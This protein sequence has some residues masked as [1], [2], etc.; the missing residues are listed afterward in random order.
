MSEIKDAV[1][2]FNLK[3]LENVTTGLPYDKEMLNQL[4]WVNITIF[5]L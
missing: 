2:I 4:L 5:I 1:L 3:E